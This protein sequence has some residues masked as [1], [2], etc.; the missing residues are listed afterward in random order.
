MK[1]NRPVSRRSFLS[2]VA[3]AG[4]AS[5]AAAGAQTGVTNRDP[6]DPVGNGRTRITDKDPIDRLGY[7]PGPRCGNGV[8]NTD[9]GDV[10]G[11]GRT[12]ITDAD[13]RGDRPNY[14]CRRRGRRS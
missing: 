6:N 3:G 2:I 14:G 10:I 5:A 4:L 1:P 9:V 12:G 13:P 8:T 7:R 11:Y